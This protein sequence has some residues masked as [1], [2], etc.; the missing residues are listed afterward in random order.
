MAT[1]QKTLA[2]LA[3]KKINER[4]ERPA[5]GACVSRDVG[6]ALLVIV[7]LLERRHREE[8]VVLGKSEERERVVHKDV[9]VEN[10]HFAKILGRRCSAAALA[11]RPA[12][13]FGVFGQVR[14]DVL[15]LKRLR[16]RFGGGAL[17]CGLG[18]ALAR[19][20]AFG[21]LGRGRG[22]RRLDGLCGLRRRTLC[23]LRLCLPARGGRLAGSIS[24]G[25]S[26]FGFK[27]LLRSLRARR[28]AHFFGFGRRAVV[29][30][31]VCRF[32]GCFRKR[33]GC[34]RARWACRNSG[35][36]DFGALDAL[37]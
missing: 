8:H 16:L 36:F 33:H 37:G 19:C 9:R 35:A 27:R 31:N 15:R 10:E 22:G 21:V 24:G 14:F 23:R 12:A 32:V 25:G 26:G 6:E 18:C 17:A 7:E 20:R 11:R 4:V 5:H 29:F 28:A 3:K 13:F 2:N 30:K 1:K 34:S